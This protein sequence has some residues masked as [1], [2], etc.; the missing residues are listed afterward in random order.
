MATTTTIQKTN[1]N[2]DDIM[3]VKSIYIENRNKDRRDYFDAVIEM[4]KYPGLPVEE[5]IHQT[6]KDIWTRYITMYN[7]SK[8][9]GVE[10]NNR[11]Y[12]TKETARYLIDV[13]TS[14]GSIGDFGIILAIVYNYMPGCYH[15]DRANN[16]GGAYENTAKLLYLCGQGKITKTE[17]IRELN[18][19][20]LTSDTFPKNKINWRLEEG[21]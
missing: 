18:K 3:N 14:F 13:C 16:Y 12:D 10:F 2:G 6:L 9:A 20:L 15:P 7:E 4:S 8:D 1:K 5:I 19:A 11:G 21:L 17:V